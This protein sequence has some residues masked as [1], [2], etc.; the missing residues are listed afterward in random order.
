MRKFA[1][2]GAVRSAAI[3][4]LVPVLACGT[5]E[6]GAWQ[7]SV[8]DSAG[9]SIVENTGAGVWSAERAWAVHPSLSIGTAE[10]DSAYLF[11]RVIDIAVSGSGE[12]LVLDQAAAQVRV[13][14]ASGRFLRA[15]GSRGRGP[16]ELSTFTSGVLLVPGDSVLIPDHAQR[17]INVFALSGEPV[18]ERTIPSTPGSQSWARAAT[19]R[20]LFRGV[21]VGRDGA[22]NF[23]I[24][25][26]L[27]ALSDSSAAADTL[28]AFDYARSPLGGPGRPRVPLIVNAAFW[29]QL[30][31][32]RIAWSSLDS[33]HVRVHDAD[34][35]LRAF[36]RHAAWEA[37]PA[38]PADH[39]TLVERL[40]EKL[41]LMGGDAASVPQLDLI[42]PERLPA[43]TALRAG[44]DNTLWVQRMGSIAGID[45]FA[46]NASDRTGWLGGPLWDV[47]DARG[48]FLGTVELPERFHLLHVTDRALYGVLKDAEDVEHVVRLDLERR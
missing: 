7:G 18:R 23:E 13:F 45:P 25:D 31:D 41:R 6:N 32:G 48:R 22:G 42:Q 9:V 36:F 39:A 35:A 5:Q 24:W 26:G 28:I 15:I 17:R 30:E 10:G 40:Q 2:G 12:L 38:T 1:N 20:L 37:R 33:D 27:L 8:R 29:T 47:L 46:V 4:L 16:G 44:P 34:G 21:A 3:G 11:T 14:D 19:G 43:I